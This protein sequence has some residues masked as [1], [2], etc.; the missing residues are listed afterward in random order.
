[1]A[2]VKTDLVLM[3]D[4]RAY[5]DYRYESTSDTLATIEADA[6][7]DSL[8]DMFRTNDLIEA[9][10]TDGYRKYK[11]TRS[12]SDITLS[13]VDFENAVTVAS[14]S[15]NLPNFGT[16]TLPAASTA[17]AYTLD[18][19]IAGEVILSW[20]EP[21]DGEHDVRSR[22]REPQRISQAP[23]V[24]AHRLPVSMKNAEL[25]KHF[26]KFG[27]VRIDD[28]PE[29]YRTA[30]VLSDLEGLPYADIA[31][32][33]EVPVGTVKSRLFRGRRQLQKVLYDH[34]V[35]M[36]YIAARAGTDE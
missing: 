36:G 34:A 18:D 29:E 32:L 5:K 3:G 35:E 14:T 25:R 11:V 17:A 33:M 1:M 24:V 7:F 15:A 9:W 13:V 31:E 12:A 27:A 20:T 2:L 26:A 10:G 4:G 21:A 23:E 8:A 22:Q 28:L 19:P 6:Y 16:V 30:V